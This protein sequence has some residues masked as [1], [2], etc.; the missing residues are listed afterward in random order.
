MTDIQTDVDAT[1][2][3]TPEPALPLHLL[4]CS[5]NT[6]YLHL[7]VQP[8]GELS[9]L[10]QVDV[11]YIDPPYNTGNRDTGR[12]TYNDAFQKDEWLTFMEQRL[13]P[14][15]LILKPT[16][17]VIV[18]IDDSEV[19]RLRLLMDSIFGPSNFIAQIVVDGGNPKNNARFLSVTHDYML[20]YA[21]SRPALM[22]SGIKWRKKRDG[23]PALLKERDRLLRAGKTHEEVTTHLKTWVKTQGFAKRLKVFINSD[24]K[25][26]YTYSDLSAPGKGQTYDVLHPVTGKPCA[27]PSRG[28]G[29]VQ[30]K[31][32]TLLD[33]DLVLFGPDHTQQPMKKLYLKDTEDQVQKAILEYPSRSS[34]HLLEKLLGKRGMFNNPKNLDMMRDLI[35]LMTPK[36]GLVL[37]YFAGSGTT[38]HAVLEANRIHGT[39]RKF[40]LVTNNE[41]NIFDEITRPR[42][43]AALG[44]ELFHENIRVLHVAEDRELTWLP[45]APADAN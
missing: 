29:M 7:A 28:W 17:V 34:T 33:N 24:E 26:L 22:K 43:Q 5:E 37:D 36:D 10:N 12:F 42:I 15:R 31:M 23:V 30:E 18:S 41:N 35:H 16:G 6:N 2:T 32:Q 27:V 20:V 40:I 39:E 14:L 25:G 19:H 38:G 21:K 4:V 1:V 9:L 45:T 11:C 44:G 3:T 8:E 13:A